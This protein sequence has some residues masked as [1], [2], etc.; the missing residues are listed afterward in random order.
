MSA[1]VLS[2]EGLAVSF[3]GDG[4]RVR[5]VDGVELS[6]GAGDTLALVGESGCGKTMTALS[7]LRL[8][9]KPGRID[10]G[11]IRIGGHDVLALPVAALRRLRGR[12]A[13]MIFQEPSTSLNPVM[14]A[15]VQVVEAIRLHERV[16]YDE[17]RRRA[18]ELF[19]RV[20]IPDPSARLD[21]YPHQ[22]SGGMRQRVMIAIAL[23]AKPRLLIADEPTTALDVTIQAQI[24]ELLRE[25]R[26]QT[27]MAVLL[28]THD[29]GIVN[30]IA[31]RVAVMYAGQLVE[32]GTRERVLGAPRH[33]YTQGLLASIPA[34]ATRGARLTEI[35]GAVPSPAA[36]PSGCRFHPRCPLSFEPCPRVDPDWTPIEAAQRARCHLVAQGLGQVKAS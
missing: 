3:P 33:P 27:G 22:L 11:T 10:A 34:R 8:V 31:E 20:G 5:V 12:E 17:A 35:R 30:E 26:S 32:V 2:V 29:L 36:W 24:L 16:G 9:P 1:P 6:L 7:L 15:G 21:A 18:A 14:T 19:D 23:A 4:A 28:I 25:L 13:A